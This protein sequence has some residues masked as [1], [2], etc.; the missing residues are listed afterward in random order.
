[1]FEEEKEQNEHHSV[2]IPK[3][4]EC[5]MPSGLFIRTTANTLGTDPGFPTPE[6]VRQP[7]GRTNVLFGQISILPKP[8]YKNKA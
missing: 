3:Q 1:M 5:H 7:Q 6:G 4:I 8:K 2:T